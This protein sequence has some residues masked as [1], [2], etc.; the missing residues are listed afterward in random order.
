MKKRFY[1]IMKSFPV[2]FLKNWEL[3]NVNNTRKRQI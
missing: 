1:M 2:T 3:Y